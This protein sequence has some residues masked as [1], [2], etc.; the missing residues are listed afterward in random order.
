M[1]SARRA[2]AELLDYDQARS[3][4]EKRDARG[5]R[6][7]KFVQS[8]IES[9]KNRF[10][11]V[12]TVKRNRRKLFPTGSWSADLASPARPAALPGR[13]LGARALP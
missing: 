4:T 13:S 3:L 10:A 9:H 2:D 5:A 7:K 6:F 11:A 12:T 1:S 8:A